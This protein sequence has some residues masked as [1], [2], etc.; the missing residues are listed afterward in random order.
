MA[1]EKFENK[2]VVFSRKTNFDY[3]TLNNGDVLE[4][5]GVGPWGGQDT[6]NTAFKSIR[7]SDG[8]KQSVYE[9]DIVDYLGDE[10]KPTYKSQVIGLSKEKELQEK[11]DKVELQLSKALMEL[12][13]K[14][15]VIR[16]QKEKNML[17][18][19]IIIN[20]GIDYEAK[21]TI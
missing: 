7:L 16:K 2:I 3:T 4:L 6:I 19:V 10:F 8:L 5:V 13:I 20:G 15:K 21:R 9:Q 1:N 17:Q 12:E 11:L 14:N 18:Q